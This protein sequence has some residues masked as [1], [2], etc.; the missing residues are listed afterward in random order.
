VSENIGP[1]HVAFVGPSA[2]G[3]TTLIEALVPLLRAGGLRLGVV[4]HTHHDVDLEV[5]GKDSWRFRE[6]GASRVLLATPRRLFA[7]GGVSDGAMAPLVADLDLVL[8]EGG[9]KLP[10]AK[11]LVGEDLAGARALGTAGTVIG[12]VGASS[13]GLPSFSRDDAEGVAEFLLSYLASR[14]GGRLDALIDRAVAAHGHL[15]PGQVLGVRM[16]VAGIEA[17][18]L[19]LPPHRKRLLVFVEN[20][21]CATDAIAS[22]TGCS[23]GKRSLRYIPFAKMAATFVDLDT[24]RAVRV[25]ARDDSRG[26]VADFAQGETEAHAAQLVAYRSMPDA[27]L[28]AIQE[29][30]V[31]LAEADLPGARRARTPCASCG[32]HV[33]AGFEAPL[34]GAVLCRAC[35]GEAYYLPA[36]LGDQ[37]R[38]AQVPDSQAEWSPQAGPLAEASLSY[39]HRS[40][41]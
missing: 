12:S 23:L 13:A 22:A 2:G 35:A 4:K 40:A 1:L 38:S 16:A 33:G 7:A 5:P 32:E 39:G 18:G 20:D 8:H 28:L 14:G 27:L 29:V 6:A 11:I 34:R 19:A 3:K 21:R 37:R 31:P 36:G 17:L 24:G 10:C 25:A 41:P 9:R 15:C 26:R 30:R